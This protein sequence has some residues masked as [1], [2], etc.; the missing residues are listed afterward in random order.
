MKAGET[1]TFDVK[2]P[3]DYGASRARRQGRAPSRSPSTKSKSASCPRS[4]THFAKRVSQPPR[5]SLE[6]KDD[7][8]RRLDGVA[9]QKARRTMSAPSCSTSSSQRTISRCPEVLVEREID[10][11]LD[12][13]RAVRRA[14]W[15]IS[16][17]ELP[18]TR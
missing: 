14:R 9:A 2:F 7:C 10:G 16:W 6:L 8:A 13:S 5:R 18:R 12:E 1:K 15:G 3:D 4:T 11:L 17:D